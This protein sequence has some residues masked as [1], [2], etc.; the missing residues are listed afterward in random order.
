MHVLESI[1]EE[2][3]NVPAEVDCVRHVGIG[4]CSGVEQW[5]L[6]LTSLGKRDQTGQ[7][8]RLVLESWNV[9]H[10]VGEIKGDT[11]H[12]CDRHLSRHRGYHR[13]G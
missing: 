9:S 10:S 11:Y 5:C 2:V 13:G 6:D 7:E 1:R 8:D 12:S 3:G 4:D